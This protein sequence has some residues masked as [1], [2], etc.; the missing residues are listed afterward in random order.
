MIILFQKE[1]CPYCQKVRQALSDLDVEWFSATKPSEGKRT[2]SLEKL[3]GQD[4][5]PFIID[6][7]TGVMMYESDD[8]VAYLIK[9]YGRQ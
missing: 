8:I 4:Q 5:V 2:G 7:D 3:G 1:E 6:T 9:T